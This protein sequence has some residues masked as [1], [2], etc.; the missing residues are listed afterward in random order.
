VGSSRG[1]TVSE[2]SGAGEDGKG[3]S[4]KTAA[5]VIRGTLRAFLRDSGLPYHF[6]DSLKWERCA[7]TREQ[8][9]FTIDEG[10]RILAWFLSKR[11]LAEYVSLRLRFRGATPSEVR[12]IRVGDEQYAR[13]TFSASRPDRIDEDA[14]VEKKSVPDGILHVCAPSSRLDPPSQGRRPTS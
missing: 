14:L 3:V 10:D 8:D 7:P 5:N 4:E 1:T 11:P 6:L 2:R 13:A 12:G 9:P